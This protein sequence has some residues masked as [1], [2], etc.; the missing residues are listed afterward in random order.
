METG[1]AQ[2]IAR[3]ECVILAGVT[4]A[5]LFLRLYALDRIPSVVFHDECDNLVNVYQI[6][7]GRGPGFFGIDWKPQPAA[8]IYIVSLAVRG[9]MS[10]FSLRAVTALFSVAA[11]VPY[12]LLLRRAVSTPAA[13]LA[14][15]LLATDIWYLHFSRAGWDN[16]FVCVPA[17]A[18]LL[19]IDGAVA[20]GRIRHFAWAGVWSAIGAYGYPAG[21]LILPAVVLAGVIGLLTRRAE[22]RRMGA[23]IVMTFGVALALCVPQVPTALHDWDRYLSRARSVFVF[24]GDNEQKSAPEK[25]G[26]VLTNFAD[27]SMQLFTDW[28]PKPKDEFPERYLRA[29]DGAFA[30]PTVV[31]LICGMLMSVTSRRWLSAA[32]LWW[33]FLLVLLFGTQA[34]TAGSSLN[35]ARGI[36]FVPILY[37]FVGL[38]LQQIW[39]V[40]R[41][42]GRL[43]TGLVIA[44]VLALSAWT[45]LQYF[46]WVQS[47][48]TL[49]ALQPAIPVEEFPAWQARAWQWTGETDGFYNLTM[50]EADKRALAD[51]GRWP[52]AESQPAR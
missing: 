32:R 14:S 29:E 20:T 37:L 21:R 51:S 12:Y 35:G 7:H 52:P 36:A 46:R 23:G 17:T 13:L 26:V 45:T 40:G 16:V 44:V 4:A 3:W 31:L 10:V 25:V 41:R 33:L 9:A 50:W 27:K 42:W 34:L 43:G 6:L 28:I 22:R 47:P 18:A 38:A 19:S 15:W 48:E 39:A 5:A 49:D 1:A 2:P 11:L 24:A 30:R 8:S